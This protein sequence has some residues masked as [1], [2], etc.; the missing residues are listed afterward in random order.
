MSIQNEAKIWSIPSGQVEP[1]LNLCNSFGGRGFSVGQLPIEINTVPNAMPVYS[2]SI[3]HAR[4]TTDAPMNSF[5]R[6]GVWSRQGNGLGCN[7]KNRPII[8][9]SNFEDNSCPSFSMVPH[10]QQYLKSTENLLDTANWNISGLQQV[11]SVTNDVDPYNE[12]FFRYTRTGNQ[13]HSNGLGGALYQIIG[14]NNNASYIFLNEWSASVFLKRGSLNTQVGIQLLNNSFS[15]DHNN[16]AIFNFETE[17][18]TSLISPTDVQQG[19][20]DLFEVEK[21]NNG[22]YRIQMRVNYSFLQEKG[23]YFALYALKVGTTPAQWKTANDNSDYTS[24]LSDVGQFFDVS[25]PNVTTRGKKVTAPPE[26]SL[27]WSSSSGIQP[28]I[29]NTSTTNVVFQTE[30]RFR[31]VI[32]PRIQP[33]GVTYSYYFDIW[34]SDDTP[35]IF[36]QFYEDNVIAN[37]FFIAN[38][39]NEDYYIESPKGKLSVWVNGATP[40]IQGMVDLPYGRNQV[41]FQDNGIWING[42][43]YDT[44]RS[45]QSGTTYFPNTEIYGTYFDMRAET[46]YWIKAFGVWERN[47]TNLEIQSL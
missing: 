32:G 17:Q 27:N 11:N 30:T 42:V 12:T 2:D 35:K 26:S 37:P 43:Q 14:Y 25:K 34:V 4:W 44:D 9:F 41:V 1:R 8:D 33:A 21:Y 22:W 16:Y 10:T 18:I 46:R 20:S 36:A 7:D 28:Y 40:T 19:W 15:N 6:Q 29:R 13:Y 45:F 3:R 24:Y 31:Q 23:R 38:V 39:I 5:S 47:L